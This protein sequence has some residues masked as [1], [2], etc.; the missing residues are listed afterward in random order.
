MINSEQG[1][2]YPIDRY[3]SYTKVS[4]RYMYFISTMANEVVPRC[5]V[6]AQCDPKWV[7]VVQ[8]EILALVKNK[9]DV[10]SVPEGAHLV[11]CK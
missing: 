1:M 5:L 4:K 9:W 6:D 11:G 8:E 3:V 7:K 2:S 10:V